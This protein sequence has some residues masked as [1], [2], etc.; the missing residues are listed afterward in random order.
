MDVSVYIQS[1]RTNR[2]LNHLDNLKGFFFIL[3]LYG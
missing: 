3:D 2:L 1:Y